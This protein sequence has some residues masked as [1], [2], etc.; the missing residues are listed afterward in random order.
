MWREVHISPYYANASGVEFM[1][2]VGHE[3][4][5]A[6]HLYAIPSFYRPYSERA[7]YQYAFNV[8]TR[9]GY[10]HRALST[11]TIARSLNYWGAYPEINASPFF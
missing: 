10:L 4:I 6:Y 5:H 2:C 3:L 7:A 9:Y 8:Y 11:M 1:E